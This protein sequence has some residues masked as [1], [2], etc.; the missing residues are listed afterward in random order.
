MFKMRSEILVLKNM[1][2]LYKI[3]IFGCQNTNFCFS[4]LAGL[5]WIINCI[6]Y[7]IMELK[8]W[9]QILSAGLWQQLS[10]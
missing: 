7:G 1:I 2:F 5:I 9:I 3:Q 4:K 8:K 6:Q 10:V